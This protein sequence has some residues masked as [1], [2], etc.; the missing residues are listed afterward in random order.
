MSLI[1]PASTGDQ[2][3]P[4]KGLDCLYTANACTHYGRLAIVLL[5]QLGQRLGAL[6]TLQIRLALD[7]KAEFLRV[8]VDGLSG[9]RA[10]VPSDFAPILPE[11]PYRLYK[12]LVLLLGPVAV[13]LTPDQV[14]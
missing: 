8:R 6:C 1:L 5:V 4:F 14:D 12:A 7:A 10:H 11:E 2:Q 3:L 9:A 13:P